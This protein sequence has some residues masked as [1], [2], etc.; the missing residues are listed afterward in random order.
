MNQLY[1]WAS[2]LWILSRAD[3][4]NA[5]RPTLVK[6]TPVN[7]PATIWGSRESAGSESGRLGQSLRFRSSHLLWGVN[8]SQNSL[9]T[10]RLCIHW[11]PGLCSLGQW[12]GWRAGRSGQFCFCDHLGPQ[13]S[14][15]A[16][17]TLT[18]PLCSLPKIDGFSWTNNLRSLFQEEKS[19]QAI[20]RGLLP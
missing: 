14:P 4:P 6:W 19:P 17:W 13:L 18:S 3:T 11:A 16:F 8:W 9:C 12:G 5:C 7:A 10:A 1:V 20:L 2:P 15:F